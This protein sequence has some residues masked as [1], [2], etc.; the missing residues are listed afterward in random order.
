MTTFDYY[1]FLHPVSNMFW[2]MSF[3]ITCLAYIDITAVR[4]VNKSFNAWFSI[5]TI[6]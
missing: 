2:A 5:W 4:N 6:L 3:K 1:L